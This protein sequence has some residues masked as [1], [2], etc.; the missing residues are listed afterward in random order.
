MDKRRTRSD[1][2]REL[3]LR[4]A[5]YRAITSG[6]MSTG[7]AVAS[8]RRISKLTQPEFAK[9]RNLSVQSLRAIEADNANPTVDTLNKVAAIFGLQVGFVPKGKGS[10]SWREIEQDLANAAPGVDPKKP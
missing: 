3:Q 5:L 9:H 1:A 2:A 8:L 4:D 6:D 7:Q 10:S